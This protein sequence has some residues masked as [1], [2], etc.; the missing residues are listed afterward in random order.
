MPLFFSFNCLSLTFLRYLLSLRHPTLI[1][2]WSKTASTKQFPFIPVALNPK[3]DASV[4][5][6]RRAFGIA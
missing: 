1:F 2:A 4:N 6:A 5:T 3:D